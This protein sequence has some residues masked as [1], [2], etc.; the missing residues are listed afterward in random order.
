MKGRLILT[1][2]STGIGYALAKAALDQGWAVHGISRREPE[3]LRGLPGWS[4]E[5][6]DLSVGDQVDG[7]KLAPAEEGP[8]ILVNN[9][10]TIGPIAA[11]AG[12]SWAAVEQAMALNVVAPMRL[13]ARF[14][15]EVAGEKQVYFTG[16]GAASF[17]IEGWSTYCAS[18]AAVHQY[19]EVVAKEYPA[20]K[21]HAF[22]PGKVDTPMQAVIREA[23]DAAFAMKQGFVEDY[24]QGKLV[25]PEAVAEALLS[26]FTTDKPLPVVVSL[27]D[28]N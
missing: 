23:D 11:V 7:V 19:A 24:E 10:G 18:K 25:A 16:S 12:T 17:A 26:I 27:T 15:A 13:T 28:L 6:A 8:T 5:A 3:D 9:A 21:V 22:R 14:L 4:F 20:V 1:G 2:V